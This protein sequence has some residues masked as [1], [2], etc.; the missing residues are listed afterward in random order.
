MIYL[1][2]TR[3]FISGYYLFFLENMPCGYKKYIYS[4][5]RWHILDNCF[6]MVDWQCCSS[7]IFS[8]LSSI[9]VFY[10]FNSE[11]LKSSTIILNYLF[12]PS[13]SILLYAFYWMEMLY[14]VKMWKKWPSV[15]KLIDKSVVYSYKW[16]ILGH[17]TKASI[18]TSYIIKKKT[19]ENNVEKVKSQ[20]NYVLF[21]FY[22]YLWERNL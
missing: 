7:L 16:S 19:F 1:L 9:H 12:L 8:C 2:I 15:Y 13:L 3:I 5:V 4:V 21:N 11:I 22:E 17:K 14:W 20:K 10:T 18:N 6:V